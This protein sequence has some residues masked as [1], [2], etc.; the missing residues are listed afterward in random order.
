[1]IKTVIITQILIIAIVGSS[2]C[3]NL[4]KL[5]Q[6]DFKAPYKAEVIHGVGIIPPIAVVTCW[7]SFDEEA[8][9]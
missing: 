5:T 1:M 9:E 4:Y 8:V 6:C 3:L 7:L 2:W